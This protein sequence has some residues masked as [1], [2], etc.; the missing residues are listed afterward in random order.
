MRTINK[1]QTDNE[2]HEITQER[3]STRSQYQTYMRM[4]THTSLQLFRTS[5]LAETILNEHLGKET[6]QNLSKCP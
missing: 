5:P 3:E 2:I 6:E 4:D 1:R